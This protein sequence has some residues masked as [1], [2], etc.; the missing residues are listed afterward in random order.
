MAFQS[1]TERDDA[2]VAQVERKDSS[3]KR[4]TAKRS[5]SSSPRRINN[6]RH[7]GKQV[8]IFVTKNASLTIRTQRRQIGAA[9]SIPALVHGALDLLCHTFR[10]S[11]LGIFGGVGVRKWQAMG[12]GMLAVYQVLL[13]R[14]QHAAWTHDAQ[15]CNAFASR[16]PQSL[17]EPQRDKRSRAPQA[18][19]AMHSHDTLCPVHRI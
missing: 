4:S 6:I 7:P 16:P 19:Q 8:S 12:N 17:H 10:L 14:P 13:L 15:P 2:Q 1:T 9:V 11:L 18:G 5:D 3:T